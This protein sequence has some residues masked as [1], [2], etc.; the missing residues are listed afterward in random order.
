MTSPTAVFA[1]STS[2]ANRTSCAASSSARIDGQP[3][4]RRAGL[5]GRIGDGREYFF[6][7]SR[8][9]GIRMRA[10]GRLYLGINDESLDD[11]AGSFR[12]TIRY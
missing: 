10:A 8:R 1:R 5:I 7:G 3:S 12:V 2:C 6:V 11:N 9:E 4:D